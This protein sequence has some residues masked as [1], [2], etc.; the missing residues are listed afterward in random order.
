MPRKPRLDAPGVLHH[1]MGRGIERM[2]IFDND[3]D[4][5]DFLLRLASQCQKTRLIVYAWA[6]MSNHFHLLLRTGTQPLS[7]VMKKIL[8]GYVVNF[9]RR[10]ARSGHL[11]QNRYKSIVCEDDPY[12]LEL[13]R[14]IHLNPLR[15]GIVDGLKK[16]NNYPW[17]GH[18]ALMGKVKRDWQDTETILDYFGKRRKEASVKYEEYV[19]EG[20]NQGRRPDLGGGG[21][22]RSFRGWSEVVSLRRKGIK[23]ASDDRILGRGEFVEGI[24]AEAAEREKET[25]RLRRK[26][27]DLGSSIKSVG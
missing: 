9:N 12:L 7:A 20:V 24:I 19:R 26:G 13:S 27:I 5:N 25:L 14:Y 4:R 6:L 8:T 2:N 23:V 15:A 17:T 10:H 3:T 1:V 21:L 18:S 22:I 16:L 11:F